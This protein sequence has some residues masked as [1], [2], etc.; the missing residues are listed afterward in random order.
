M[1]DFD[2][3]RPKNYL[4]ES[5]LATIFCCLPFGVAGIVFA[6]RV[7][8]AYD[9]GDYDEAEQASQD[10]W[11]WTKISIIIGVVVGV[12][13]FVGGIVGGMSGM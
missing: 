2:R 12:L 4:V 7:N 8:S 13:S 1:E 9:R 11:K 6:S 5:I 3:P 10:A